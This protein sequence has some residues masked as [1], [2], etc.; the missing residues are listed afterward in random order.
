M[1][2]GIKVYDA[3]TEQPIFLSPDDT[4]E[5]CA[6]IMQD[7]HVGTVII[8]EGQE[9]IGIISDQDIVRKVIAKGKNPI[10]KKVKDFME[11]KLITITPDKDIFEAIVMMR[12]AN[13]R[14][15]PVVDGPKIMGLLTLK[16]IL[17]I[18][19]QLFE[20]LIDQ[21]NLREEERKPINRNKPDEGVCELCGEYTEHIIL[22]NGSRVCENCQNQV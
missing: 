22:K 4:L 3:M 9:V 21:I 1:Q 12:D 10:G 17:K 6:A 19:P 16:D 2:T 20:L 11:T 15:L 13:I 18:E 8:Q 14:H 7:K 5:K